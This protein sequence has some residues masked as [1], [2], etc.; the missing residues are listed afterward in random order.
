MSVVI[1]AAGASVFVLVQC[2]ILAAGI[3]LSPCHF[4]HRIQFQLPLAAVSVAGVAL[5]S[6]FIRARWSRTKAPG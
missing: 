2:A 3:L 5:V 6:R 1:D 4:E